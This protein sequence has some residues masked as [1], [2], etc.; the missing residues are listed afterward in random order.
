[1]QSEDR[2]AAPGTSV[3]NRPSEKQIR[4]RLVQE[5]ADAAG[6]PADRIDVREPFASYNIASVEAVHLVGVLER[7]L[8]LS[9]DPTLLWDHA[10]IE[11]LARHLAQVVR[12]PEGSSP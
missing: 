7:W 2:P 10:T 11:A 9:L 5:I 3:T 12:S 6:V 1:M 4:D 8:G